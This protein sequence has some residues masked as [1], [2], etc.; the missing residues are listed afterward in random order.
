MGDKVRKNCFQLILQK[1]K[2]P[3]IALA[4]TCFQSIFAPHLILKIQP[5][6]WHTTL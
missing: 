5:I 2:S 4:D 6:L 3:K 1:V